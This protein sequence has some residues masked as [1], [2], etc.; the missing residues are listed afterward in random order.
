MSPLWRLSLRNLSRNRRRNL[1]TASAVALGYAALILIGA[2]VT[3]VESFLRVNA[4][5]LQHHGHVAVFQAEGLE[6]AAAR[7]ARY[8]LTAADQAQVL[9]AIGGDPRVE[10]TGRYLRGMGLAGNGCRT[11]PFVGIGVELDVYRRAIAHPEVLRVNPEFAVPL[12]GRPLPEYRAVRGAV[13]LAS[14]LARLL[15]KPRVHDDFPPDAELILVPDCTA[16]DA[17]AQV[18]SDAN[19]QLAGLSFD[20]SLAA[21]DGEV[22]NIFRTPSI[23]TEDQTVLTSLETLQELYGT[24]AVTYLAVYLRDGRETATFAADLARRLESAGVASAVYAYDDDRLNPFYVGTMA[25]LASLVTFIAFLVTSVVA[26]GVMNAMTLT[27]LERTQEMGTFRA[28]GYR[29][30]HLLGLYVRE[31]VLLAAAAL[32][33]GLVLAYAASAL[34]NALDLRISPPGV[35]GTLRVYIMP[36]AGV[37]L[38]AA[39]LLLPLTSLVTWL[40]VRRRARLETATLLTMATA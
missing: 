36:G 8:S 28:L 12:R 26:L 20:G 10:F 4:I 37:A 31:S 22:V 7:P 40:V 9:E 23:D 25:F 34:V 5:Y 19:V 27:M 32:A 38:A 33:A 3:R 29:R 6:K 14:G 1:A 13:G 11:V 30:R 35:P 18:A 15:N 39:A 21:V 2:W 17:A 24:D 16:P